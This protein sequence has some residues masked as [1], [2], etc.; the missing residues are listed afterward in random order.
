MPGHMLVYEN[1]VFTSISRDATCRL[2]RPGIW[3]VCNSGKPADRP[4]LR[5]VE[6]YAD[7][8][9]HGGDLLIQTAIYRLILLP[10]G[11]L[12]LNGVPIIANSHRATLDGR[13]VSRR[14]V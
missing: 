10:R 9:A 13:V 11:N 2:Y 5:V 1:L 7:V 4:R 12:C 8:I 14:A 3:L 6:L